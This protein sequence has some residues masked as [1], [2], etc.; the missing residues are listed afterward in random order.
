MVEVVLHRPGF[1]ADHPALA[2]SKRWVRP[3]PRS[4]AMCRTSAFAVSSKFSGAG[5]SHRF[6]RQDLDSRARETKSNSVS[7]CH[8]TEMGFQEGGN[9][10]IPPR[11]TIVRPW[12]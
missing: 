12:R 8:N 3:E 9:L 5:G 4:K 10:R 7:D 1:A 11:P 2:R 6:D